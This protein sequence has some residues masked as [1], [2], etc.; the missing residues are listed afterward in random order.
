[1]YQRCEQYDMRTVIVASVSMSLVLSSCYYDMTKRKQDR[2]TLPS[3]LNSRS[4]GV[5]TA[6]V[7]K[8][9]I[10]VKALVD[11]VL[12]FVCYFSV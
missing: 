5:A 12:T 9:S 1:V 6:A 11:V 4:Q 8:V 2:S 10:V 3:Q 7:S